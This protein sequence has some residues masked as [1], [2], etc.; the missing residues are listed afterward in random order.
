MTVVFN[1]GAFGN[2]RR[3]QEERFGNRLIACDLVNPDFVAFAEELRRRGDAGAI[4]GGTA[5]KPC[6]AALPAATARP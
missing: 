1:D 6:A 3:I 5:A 4:A 2:V